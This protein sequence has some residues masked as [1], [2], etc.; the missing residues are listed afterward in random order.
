MGA[1]DAAAAARQGPRGDSGA[2]LGSAV[3]REEDLAGGSKG[4]VQRGIQLST[5]A[6][7]G[8]EIQRIQA[9]GTA[10]RQRG[11]GS[12][13][14]SGVHATVQAVGNDVGSRGRRG[15]P[16][17]TPGGTQRRLGAGLQGVPES[18]ALGPTGRPNRQFT[19]N[20][21][22]S[23]LISNAGCDSTP[24]SHGLPRLVLAP[25]RLAPRSFG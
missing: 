22:G 2:A 21:K 3:L 24:P 20:R 16:A 6:Q 14:Q 4:R 18:S 9:S 15:D 8:D 7:Q 17:A 10:D 11:D 1:A 13:V 25:K 23:R 12:G 19:A 5:D